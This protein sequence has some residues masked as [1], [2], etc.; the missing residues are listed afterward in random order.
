MRTIFLA[1]IL[2]LLIS[3]PSSVAQGHASYSLSAHPAAVVDARYTGAEGA[4]VRGVRTYR[5]LGDALADAP[6]ANARPYVILLRAGR[7]REK[8]TV[9]K[10]NVTLL[11]EDRDATVLTYD[12]ASDTRGPTGEPYGTRGSYT[13]RIAAPD[14]R[15]ENLTV[16]NA[17]DYPANAA[18]PDGDS[19]RF[20]NTQAVAVITD[21]GSDRAAFVNVKLSGYQDTV[22]ANVGRHWFS[23]CIILG[24]V[25][26][27]FGAGQAVFDDCDI[28]SRDRGNATNNGYVVAPSTSLARPYGFLFIHSRL[29]KESAS[30]APGSVALGRPWHPSADAQAVGSAVFVDCWMDDHISAAGWDRLSS[31]NAGVAR[32]WFEPGDARLFE[33]RST[34]PGAAASPSRRVLSAADAA[35]YSPDA[36][37]AG[38]TP[39]R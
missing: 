5:R 20:R 37:L 13:L 21:T 2:P 14:F 29:K 15:A 23:R 31:V 32:I 6:A 9:D 35:Y 19:T 17:F 10:A 22:F 39:W 11:G 26:F 27:I 36:V 4:R 1:A 38:W 24:N 16:E 30:M 12:A 8:L 33:L 28:V 3:P 18:K 34:G 25:D 7:Y